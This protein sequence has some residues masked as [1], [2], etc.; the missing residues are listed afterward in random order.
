MLAIFKNDVRRLMEQKAYLTVAIV[1]TICSVIAAVV[2]TNHVVAKGNIALVTT[3]VEKE[4]TDSP[5]FNVSVRSE[6]PRKSELVQNRY[7]A[8]VYMESDGSYRIETIKSDEFKGMLTSFLSNPDTFRPDSDTTRHIGTNI[9]G[10]MMMFLLIQG[11]LY[12]KLFADD[13]EKHMIE[14]V[15]ISPIAF[16]NYLLGHGIFTILL[17]FVPSYSVI[18]AA[19][20]FGVNIG[21]GLLQYAGLIGILSILSTAFSLFL[22]SLFYVADTANMVGSS[23]ITLTSILAGSFYSFSKEDSLFSR[24]LHILP[25]KDFINFVN[26][27]EK[28]TLSGKTELQFLYV[29]LLSITFF[30]FASFKTRKDYVYHR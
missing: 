20:L 8:I 11:M 29:I 21:L 16:R 22:N 10:Y 19:K 14:R 1:L 17:I 2:L 4:L 18:V 28:G 5:Y 9:I 30:V 27:L 13:K 6:A 12:G 25:Q 23:V 7:D 15:A 3:S 24:I 26:A